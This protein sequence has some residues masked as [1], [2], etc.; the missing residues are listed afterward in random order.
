MVY[1]EFHPL[2]LIV[3]QE[4]AFTACSTFIQGGETAAIKAMQKYIW[5][6]DQLSS[7]VGSSD[8]MSPG[9]RNALNS[10]TGLSPYLA[11][12]CLSPRYLYDEVLY[13]NV[14]VFETVARTGFSMNLFSEIT[15]HFAA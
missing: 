4:A 10:T 15:S 9:K 14:L 12:G 8:S 5:E 3:G 11:T 7:Y 1:G 6:D 2:V 13:M